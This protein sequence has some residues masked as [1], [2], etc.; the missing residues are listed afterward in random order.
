MS[1]NLLCRQ[2]ATSK[3]FFHHY[4]FADWSDVESH[5]VR[6]KFHENPSVGWK[7]YLGGETRWQ[8]HAHTQTHTHTHTHTHAI[9]VHKLR[10]MD[11]N[12]E[13]ERSKYACAKGSDEIGIL[14][15]WKYLMFT[16]RATVARVIIHRPNVP[17]AINTL[18]NTPLWLVGELVS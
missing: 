18:S 9:S 17:Y 13:L 4:N 6:A 14:P 2:W 1:Y 5:D 12:N 8:A 7:N 3:T 11:K 15:S 10:E 16:G